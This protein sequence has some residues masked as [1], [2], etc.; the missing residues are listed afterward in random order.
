MVRKIWSKIKALIQLARRF[1]STKAFSRK[2]TF[3]FVQ[4]KDFLTFIIILP[5]FF[6][7]SNNKC[8]L[9]AL[10][11][12]LD[13][14]DGLEPF[15]HET[16]TKI[17]DGLK[18]LSSTSQSPDSDQTPSL[19]LKTSL[20]NLCTHKKTTEIITEMPTFLVP[21]SS[22]PLAATLITPPLTS[23]NLPS[24]ANSQMAA[25]M[26]MFNRTQP[27]YRARR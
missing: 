19:S 2:S 8:Y 6:K 20:K 25:M 26:Q 4:K 21:P 3:S 13:A 7:P 11:D 12:E 9:H 22:S 5:S 24:A 23:P 17:H 18:S 16:I 15:V 1:F 14:N 10:A 27:S